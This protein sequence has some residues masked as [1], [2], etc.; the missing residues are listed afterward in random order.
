[1]SK[2]NFIIYWQP[3]IG[4]TYM[5]GSNINYLTKDHVIFENNFFPAGSCIH[6]WTSLGNYQDQR[7]ARQLPLLEKGCQYDIKLDATTSPQKTLY[8]Q[9]KFYDRYESLLDVVTIKDKQ[10][11]FVYPNDAYYYELSL[12]NGGLKEIIFHNLVITDDKLMLENQIFEDNGLFISNILNETSESHRLQIVFAEPV[13]GN[14][15]VI[16]KQIIDKFFDVIQVTS[17]K[18]FAHFYMSNQYE[19]KILATIAKLQEDYEISSVY[20][21]GYGPISS[22]AAL[23]Y[24]SKIV[25]GEAYITSDCGELRISRD[26]LY[27]DGYQKF[28]REKIQPNNMPVHSYYYV[29]FLDP[30]LEFVQPS[31][32]LSSRLYEYINCAS[33]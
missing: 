7:S 33:N 11:S 18:L 3:N 24:S 15:A 9:L 30:S 28:E 25:H 17:S 12:I 4:K 16:P 31:L 20:F 2:Q 32:D 1:M 23:Y 13:H 14:V 21:I 27:T 5:Y 26:M 29:P 19:K 8:I 22:A 10:G 6:S